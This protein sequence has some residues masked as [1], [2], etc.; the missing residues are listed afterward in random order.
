LVNEEHITIDQL[1]R[2][3]ELPLAVLMESLLELE[4]AGRIERQAGQRVAIAARAAEGG[5]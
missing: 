4:L 2:T 5:E 1:V 3:S